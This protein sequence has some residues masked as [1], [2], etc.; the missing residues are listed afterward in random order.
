MKA[1]KWLAIWL[2]LTASQ[3]A[4]GQTAPAVP[5]TVASAKLEKRVLYIGKRGGLVAN[6]DSADHREELVYRDSV[7]GVARIYYSSGKLRSMVP[8]VHFERDIRYGVESSFYETGEIKSRCEYKQNKVVGEALTYYRNG[9]VRSKAT[10]DKGGKQH[11]EYFTPE[12]L[13]RAAPSL[14]T[15]KMPMFHHGGS[16]EIVAY[17]Q[18][19][20]TYPVEAMRQQIQGK[21]EVAF[22]VDEAGF[23]R[24]IHIEKTP[25][26]LFNATV[27]QAV[28][29]MGRLTPGEQ[30]GEPVSVSFAVPITFKIN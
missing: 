9:V 6:P 16:R 25:S 18:H 3:I 29:S 15:A 30:E 22:T 21:V 19:R 12:G 8:Y 17:I 7:G 5:E 28:A 11:I 13:P 2:C 23:I 1:V 4:L 10:T 27:M 14:E 26:P 20:V 24:H